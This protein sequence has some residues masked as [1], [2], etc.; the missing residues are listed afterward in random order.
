MSEWWKYWLKENAPAALDGYDRLSSQ[1]TRDPAVVRGFTELSKVVERY[2]Q[3][4]SKTHAQRTIAEIKAISDAH[5]SRA[6]LIGTIAAMQGG[7]SQANIAAAQRHKAALIAAQTAVQTSMSRGDMATVAKVKAARQTRDID[8]AIAE[9]AQTL[10]ANGLLTDADYISPAMAATFVATTSEGLG[11]DTKD[12]FGLTTDEFAER[13]KAAGVTTQVSLDTM[14]DL[15]NKA[16]SAHEYGTAVVGQINE[17]LANADRVFS[18]GQSAEA[19]KAEA[20]RLQQENAD[21]FKST[22]PMNNPKGAALAQQEALDVLQGYTEATQDL[23]MFRA[24]LQQGD[25]KAEQERSVLTNPRF[26][27]WAKQHGFQRTGTILDDGRYS[28]GADDYDAYA[29]F[30]R[31]F[32]KKRP[33]TIGR[34]AGREVAIQYDEPITSPEARAKFDAQHRTG[35]GYVKIKGTDRFMSVADLERLA[36]PQVKLLMLDANGRVAGPDAEGVTNYLFNEGS[37]FAYTTGADGN[38]VEVPI[39]E[40]GSKVNAAKDALDV[41]FDEEGTTGTVR[42]IRGNVDGALAKSLL[43][44]GRTV[45]NAEGV[46]A[47]PGLGVKVS[48]TEPS[49]EIPPMWA[50]Q[51]LRRDYNEAP[52][53]DE[54]DPKAIPEGKDP[55]TDFIERNEDT[56]EVVSEAPRTVRRTAVEVPLAASLALTTMPGDIVVR[57]DE[58]A[59]IVIGDDQNIERREVSKFRRRLSQG[60]AKEAFGESTTLAFDILR[61]GRSEE[62]KEQLKE[63]RAETQRERMERGLERLPAENVAALSTTTDPDT[64]APFTAG[65]IEELRRVAKGPPPAPTPPMPDVAARREDRAREQVDRV[66]ALQREGAPDAVVDRAAKRAA[67]LLAVANTSPQDAR[68]GRRLAALPDDASSGRAARIEGR[69]EAVQDEI[70]ESTPDP[71]PPAKTPVDLAAPVTKTKQQAAQSVLGKI[72]TGAASNKFAEAGGTDAKR[73]TV[74]GRLGLLLRGSAIERDTAAQRRQVPNLPADELSAR[75]GSAPP[76]PL[77]TAGPSAERVVGPDRKLSPRATRLEPR[78]SDAPLDIKPPRTGLEEVD[79]NALERAFQQGRGAKPAPPKP[80]G[81]DALDDF[82]LDGGMI[83]AAEAEKGAAVS[84]STRPSSA[85]LLM[86]SLRTRSDMDAMPLASANR[87]RKA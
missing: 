16:K 59:H 18:K 15:F 20:V 55:L 13:T 69:L 28:P 76:S 72:L 84:P 44:D 53:Q 4:G 32:Q 39:A 60:D 51:E 17:D 86:R 79:E 67:F 64:G 58:G 22:L 83:P 56:Y 8:A 52:S 57:T 42:S 43:V 73:A 87:M 68:L 23:A 61:S 81:G 25:P 33:P 45:T 6:K 80:P 31:Q 35:A 66:G 70:R 78:P 30:L 7:V 10:S 75:P 41:A 29:E 38:V 36:A 3:T 85:A 24:L 19:I 54:A 11:I 82:K 2:H 27:A 71:L 50:D 62:R 48:R 47:L 63:Q 37:D 40:L 49:T 77:N 9:F 46:A 21:W 5:D 1:A 12:I 65:K 74:A 26:H 14:R 34:H